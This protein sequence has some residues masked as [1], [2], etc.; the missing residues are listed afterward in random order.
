[1]DGARFYDPCTRHKIGHVGDVLRSQSVGLVLNT[2]PVSEG[3]TPR[4][5][6]ATAGRHP[7]VT[8]TVTFPAVSCHCPLTV[9]LGDRGML[10]NNER[11]DVLR[12][13]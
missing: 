6:V 13:F 2:G 10:V 5:L 8:A 12:V 4:S 7:T 11:K 1:M 3:R 9:L